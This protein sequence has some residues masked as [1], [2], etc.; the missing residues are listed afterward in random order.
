MSREPTGLSTHPN[1]R[2]LHAALPSC[3]IHTHLTNPAF[4]HPTSARP[5]PLRPGHA[6]YSSCLRGPGHAHFGP[7]HAHYGFSSPANGVYRPDKVPA[8]TGNYNQ[9]AYYLGDSGH[10]LC[11]PG[12]TSL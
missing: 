4:A 12:H 6:L 3:Q 7:G 2:L 5:R 9:G 8:S 1:P 10:A 11:S